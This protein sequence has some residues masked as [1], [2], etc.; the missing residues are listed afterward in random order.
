MPIGPRRPSARPPVYRRTRRCRRMSSISSPATRPNFFSRS[1]GGRSSVAGGETR[2]LGDQGACR[3]KRL[4]PGWLIQLLSVITNPNVAFILHAGR[5]LRHDLR[6]HHPGAIAPG[7]IG[8]ICLLLGL[9]ALNML[10]INYAGLALMLLGIAFLVIEAFNP[11]V[12][13]GLGGVIAFLLGAAMLFKIEAPGYQLSWMVVGS[14]AA[15]ILGLSAR[16][17]RLAL[18]RPQKPPAGRRAGH[19]RSACRNPRLVRRA[20]VTSSPKASAGRPTGTEAFTPGEMVEVAD[21]KDLTLWCGVGRRAT[22]RRRVSDDA[23]LSDLSDTRR[24][25]WSFFS[26]SAI[27]ILREYRARRHFHPRPLHRGQGPGPY[28]PRFPSCSR[29]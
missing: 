9:Y 7:V 10:P 11:T 16:R 17:A 22:Q 5:H 29:W 15:M 13:L 2:Q 3:S 14:A 23:R 24:R 18:A 26:S 19:A 6:I 1:T 4:K 25:S 28:H 27:R 8:T 21:V 20:K 12:V